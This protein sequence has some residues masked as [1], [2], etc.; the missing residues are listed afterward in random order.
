MHDPVDHRPDGTAPVQGG[1]ET[2]VVRRNARD[3]AADTVDRDLAVAEALEYA[4]RSLAGGNPR[5]QRCKACAGRCADERSGANVVVEVRRLVLV[6]ER[7][8]EAGRGSVRPCLA[9]LGIGAHE[10]RDL[11]QVAIGLHEERVEEDVTD[12]EGTLVAYARRLVAPVAVELDEVRVPVVVVVRRALD[13][14]DEL[15]VD[16][17]VL[18]DRI[19]RRG[20]PRKGVV[21]ERRVVHAGLPRVPDLHQP[22]VATR[23][24]AVEVLVPRDELRLK[25]AQKALR[26]LCVPRAAVD[27]PGGR[28]V[29]GR[30]DDPRRRRLRGRQRR[31]MGLPE[32]GPGEVAGIASEPDVREEP[33]RPL[34]R[35]DRA[36]LGLRALLIPARITDRDA[37][38]IPAPLVRV[39]MRRRA[40]RV[41]HP[42]RLEH[43][44]RSV[45]KVTVGSGK[46][47]GSVRLQPARRRARELRRLHLPCPNIK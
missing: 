17:L 36:Q 9:G 12:D 26:L 13:G 34:A 39:E 44:R 28:R 40:G 47:F 7:R 14:V 41:A 24:L 10:P 8:L 30:L 19:G 1:L 35:E 27:L 46:T 20:D 21:P 22:V 25:L 37:R 16:A 4:A 11:R 38:R 5:V 33:V 6:P 2:R 29:H 3:D 32:L 42:V 43:S 15:D 23:A 31:E 45:R 18:R